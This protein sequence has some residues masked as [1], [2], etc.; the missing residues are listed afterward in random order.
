MTDGKGQPGA[1]EA[2][3]PGAGQAPI[4][5][6]GG[7]K[8]YWDWIHSLE[9]EVEARG[10]DLRADVAWSYR[11]FDFAVVRLVIWRVTED[12]VGMIADVDIGHACG[13]ERVVVF[14]PR[15]EVLREIEEALGNEPQARP[16]KGHH[17][18]IMPR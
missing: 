1:A 9:S 4:A 17:R 14:R 15:A 6:H 11:D 18:G 13:P 3:D 16:H 10:R 12:G 8:E 2:V 5:V 7:S